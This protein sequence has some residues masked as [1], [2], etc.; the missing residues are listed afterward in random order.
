LRPQS[1][2]ARLNLGAVLMRKGLV[3]DA[4]DEYREAIR[5]KPDYAEAHLSLGLALE[6]MNQ[7]E[8]ARQ[9][10]QRAT[11]LQPNNAG[12]IER[13]AQVL[14][15]QGKRREAIE[16]YKKSLQVTDRG[17]V[18]VALGKELISD[19]QTQAGIDHFRQALQLEPD[20]AQLHYSVGTIY[21]GLSRNTLP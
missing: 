15:K 2:G 17:R 11:E 12:Y 8:A 5:L 6:E 21:M 3:A 13:V 19:G 7:L 9:S 16:A 10:M 18:H 20:N 14:V 4:V 1:P